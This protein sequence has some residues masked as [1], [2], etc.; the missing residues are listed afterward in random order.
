MKKLG[1]LLAF[2]LIAA[3]GTEQD[4]AQP[5][6][7]SETHS[8][9]LVSHDDQDINPDVPVPRD[10][11][12][13]SQAEM[14]QLDLKTVFDE[15]YKKASDERSS[16]LRDSVDLSSITTNYF[17]I[18]DF[19]ASSM[20]TSAAVGP[21]EIVDYGPSGQ[22]PI[23]MRKPTIYVQFNQPMVPISKLGEPLRRSSIITITP[24]ISGTY[25]WYGTKVLSFEPDSPPH[26]NRSYSVRIS[27]KT[28]SIHGKELGK[29]YEYTFQSESLEMVSLMFGSWKDIHDARIE[30]PPKKARRILVTFNQT[31]NPKTI[32]EHIQV[33]RGATIYPVTVSRPKKPE[34]GWSD[35]FI[36]RTILLELREDLPMEKRYSVR[37][38]VGARANSESS[39][40]EEDQH[41]RFRTLSSF[42]FRNHRRYSYDFPSDPEGVKNPVFLNFS[43]PVDPESA[44]KSISAEF[45]GLSMPEHIEAFGSSI[46]VAN[47]PVDYESKYKLGISGEL[48]DVY[49]RSLG[50]D[51]TVEIE[52][53]PATSYS[54]FPGYEGLNSLEAQFDPAVIYEFQNID[55]GSFK[56]NGL[57][58]DS[59]LEEAVRNQA[60]FNLVDLKPY[61]NSEGFG[62][63]NLAWNFARTY[64]DYRGRNK[65]TSDEHSMTVQVT[66][67]GLTT[68]YAYNKFLVWVNRLSTGEPVGNAR[69]I[70]EG[71]RGFKK[72]ADTD[73]NGLAKIAL[74]PSEYVRGF[75]NPSTRRYEISLA[76]ESG[77]DRVDLPV[78]NTHF[79]GNFGIYTSYPQNAEKAIPRIFL[80]SD[81]GIYR[82][83]ETL[84]F[85]GV[86]WNQKL[87]VFTPYS[88][89]YSITI[90][91]HEG[92]DRKKVASWKGQTSE[93]GGFFDTYEVPKD[94]EPG[95]YTIRYERGDFRQ[96]EV[97]QVAYF[98]R[99]NFQVL[100]KK[101]DR[102]FFL[103][104]KVSVP[105]EASYLAGGALTG[106]DLSYFWTRKPVRFRPSG[107]RWNYWVFGP[108]GWEGEKTLSS[109]EGK[110]NLQ[111]TSNL[112]TDTADHSLKGMPYRYLVEG[113]VQDI[114]RQSISASTSVIVHP[115]A[116][117]IGARTGDNKDESWWP[118][119]VPIDREIIFSFAKVGV[120][121]LPRAE[122]GECE[123]EII[124]G[125]YKAVQQKSIGARIN[126]RYEW[127]EESLRKDRVRWKNGYSEFR[128]TPEESGSYRVRITDRD[129]EDREIVTD[130]SFYASGGSWVR[131]A[132]QE[133]ITLEVEKDLYFPGDTA[134]IL[135][136]SP[137][138]KGRYLLTI[139]REEILE[140]R[141]I[142]ID[143][144][145][146]IIEIPVKEE[147]VPVMYVTLSGFIPRTAEP[148]SYY[149]PDFGRP[150][151]IFG[152][153]AIKIS[154]RSRELDIEV[155]PDKA[156][157]R[158]G[159]KGVITV[160]VTSRGVPVPNAE[161]TYLAVDR[162]VLDIINYHIPNPVSYFYDIYNFDMYGA[163]DD[164]RRLLMAPITYETSNLT[165]GDGD[166]G[167]LQRREDFTPLA[168]FEPYLTT[169]R[170]GEIRIPIEW[171]DTLTT[172]RSTAIALKGQKVGYSED[173]MYI[174]NPIN[175]K[176]A[177]PRQMR[178]RDTSLA[179]VILSN[180]DDK[181]YEVTVK[182][183]S[184]HIGL[185]GRVEKT[186]KVPAGKSYE[187]PFV[188]EGKTAGE[189][190]IIFTIRSEVLNEEL[191][192][193][194]LVEAPIIRE[195]FTTTGI[196]SGEEN[197]VEEGLLIPS[198]IGEGYGSV[199]FSLD[200]SQAP[201][202]REQLKTLSKHGNFNFT[203]DYLYAAVPGIVAPEVSTLMG[204]K[205]E[206]ESGKKLK[207]FLKVA[208]HRQMPDGGITSSE[209]SLSEESDPYCSLVT[210]HMLQI[211]KNQGRLKD[212]GPN[213]KRLKEYVSRRYSPSSLYYRLYTHYVM[214]LGGDF[215]R[216][217]TDE[218][219]AYEDKLGIS[220]YGLVGAI[221]Q[222]EGRKRDAKKVYDRVK[223]F[224]S[225]GTRGVD[226]RETYEAR[227]YFDSGYQQL[228]HLLRLGIMV[229]ENPEM[230]RRYTFS[231]DIQKGPRNWLNSHDRLWMAI[232]LN[233]LLREEN[234]GK[235][236]F[237]GRVTLKNQ[238]LMQESFS[239]LSENPV[240]TTFSLFDQ[241]IPVTGRDE[242]S[243]L[244][245]HKKGRGTLFYATTLDYA[246][247]NEVAPARDEG[248]SVY[249]Q[250]ETLDG[251]LVEEDVLELGETYRMRVIL[252]T[253]KNRGYVNLSVPIPSGAEIVDPSFSVSSSY[254]NKDGSQ[255]ETWTRETE[256]GDEIEAYEEGYI[257]G[258]YRYPIRP[259]QMIYNSEIRYSWSSLYYG[260]REITF[261]FRC[262]TPGIYPTPPAS[263]NL[264]FEPEVFGRDRG[265]LIFVR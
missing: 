209:R 38:L 139:E 13:L 137:M 111:G 136:K 67:L 123:V 151:A 169:N 63:V 99:L 18:D 53:P 65:T 103:G 150:R 79:G 90:L 97:F 3:C 140:E 24:K 201:F 16:L 74:E 181:D 85:R 138:E 143:P 120:D 179:G 211:L 233:D 133:D 183:R 40:R 89:S 1:I 224:V 226:I 141:L 208:S 166:E 94:I 60:N 210:L 222:L 26:R 240:E 156:V 148:Q 36:E 221:Y 115:A 31:V 43:H 19:D 158:P 167:K 59:G 200:S 21:L 71:F 248:L 121:G 92:W 56:I 257:W 51:S 234:P 35:N 198:N 114:D 45:E 107:D 135:V 192:G 42:R 9:N 7:G 251:D 62:K 5:T 223:N 197:L 125:S 239:G 238:T 204:R 116:Y 152:A 184:N 237:T 106:G 177:L 98:R 68:R 160:R 157:Y 163:G 147:W 232:A 101:P 202:L 108:K 25:R 69:V 164:S 190:E 153:T 134:R 199:A 154:T 72:E 217:K 39:P 15:L 105:L 23:E 96:D 170:D 162:G 161:V 49:G 91:R 95:N 165:G 78:R 245:F 112:E 37:L 159:E 259:N 229:N 55:S 205:F 191:V 258:G 14:A 242:L 186:V 218:L 80:F 128:Y 4:A 207:S 249:T 252:S 216:T 110:L 11:E 243:S 10:S 58:R 28:R 57:S 255:S 228:S 129:N 172:Y 215:D 73:S 126:T 227:Y 220:G 22:L 70:L 144:L 50:R 195:S 27:K 231:L 193:T 235:T 178:I 88:G 132:G 41:L 214:T 44:K 174:S 175:V 93:S 246:L 100:L 124:K 142:D 130:I 118:R 82:P 83:G 230:I 171:P 6:T 173:E 187:V 176:T 196:V 250:I 253:S 149:D 263:A 64:K 265:R 76:A 104:D 17:N 30:V 75:Y 213:L 203:F 29:D 225:I 32:S 264:L 145:N 189:G 262:T 212:R 66:D 244:Q 117:Y 254:F 84:T 256:Y 12:L 168:V 2:S 47:L 113:T 46:R 131:W 185:P 61:M 119:F 109:G 102:Q 146:P 33:A 86:D 20:K 206:R 180:I 188:L 122:S 8:P 247:P 127:V 241:I 34:S 52:V 260:K 87:G 236:K 54:N 155:S 182:I 81:R 261:L 219:I 77:S 48:R 194:M